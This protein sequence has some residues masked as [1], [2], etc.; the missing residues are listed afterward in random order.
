M[1]PAANASDGKSKNTAPAEDSAIIA[2]TAPA[3]TTAT[4]A[5][6]T[7]PAEATATIVTNAVALEAATNM[8]V[9]AVAAK[10]E[11]DMNAYAAPA[12]ATAE[13]VEAPGNSKNQAATPNTSVRNSN[14]KGRRNK[15]SRR[16]H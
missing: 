7:A 5:A 8:A 16:K 3:G 6:N 11:A 12:E 1:A 2:D 10:A 9:N 4:I 13:N 15:N 14:K